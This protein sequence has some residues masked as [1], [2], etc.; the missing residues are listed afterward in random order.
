[1]KRPGGSVI[2]RVEADEGG[3]GPDALVHPVEG[4]CGRMRVR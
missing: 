2:R 3:L 1:M 4:G